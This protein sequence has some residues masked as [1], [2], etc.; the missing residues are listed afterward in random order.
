M[1]VGSGGPLGPNGPSTTAHATIARRMADEEKMSF[2]TAYG[3]NGTPSRC[4][5]SWYS[6]MYVARR[7]TRPGIG[8]SL[9]PSFSTSSTWTPT[10]A[11][12]SPGMTKTCSAKNLDSVAPAMIGPPNSRSTTH[13][14]A[15]GTRLAID[16]PMPSP[17]YAS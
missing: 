11:M 8:H 10:N 12:S 13:G 3:T 9:T 2:Q 7:T 4:V 17:Q 16:A 1:I 14:P 6:C 5:I 15:T